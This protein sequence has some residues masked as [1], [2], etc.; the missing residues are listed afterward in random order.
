MPKRAKVIPFPGSI[1]SNGKESRVASLTSDQ[2][3]HFELSSVVI[4]DAE[5]IEIDVMTPARPEPRGRGRPRRLCHITTTRAELLRILTAI[6][7]AHL[8]TIHST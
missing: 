2:W 4:D 7:P 5:Y 8:P 1:P 3:L 6:R